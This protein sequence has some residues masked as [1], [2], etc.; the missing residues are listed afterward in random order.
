M[1][2]TGRQFTNK[3]VGGRAHVRQVLQKKSADDQVGQVGADD[4]QND[5]MYL[6][7]VEIGTPSQKLNLDFDTG[8]ADLWV[9]LILIYMLSVEAPAYSKLTNVKGMVDRIAIC[10]SG[11]V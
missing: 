2:Q 1:Q 10:H 4:V 11:P 8:S 3:P 9:S 6:A 5:A 7:E